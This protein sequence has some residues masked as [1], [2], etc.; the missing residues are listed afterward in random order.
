VIAMPKSAIAIAEMSDRHPP[1]WVI[2]MGRNPQ[3]FF[4]RDEAIGLFGVTGLK[5]GESLPEIGGR[6]CF[7]AELRGEA[8]CMRARVESDG[9]GPLKVRFVLHAPGRALLFE[10]EG[11]GEQRV[12]LREGRCGSRE[13]CSA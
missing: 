10:L 5:R 11:R 8:V 13:R 2:A 3:S 4:A 1:K 7:E 12:P 6:R 9:A